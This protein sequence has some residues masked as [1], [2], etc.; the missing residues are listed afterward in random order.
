MTPQGLLD[1]FAAACADY[2][3]FLGL[4]IGARLCFRLNKELFA[5]AFTALDDDLVTRITASARNGGSGWSADECQPGPSSVSVEQ[6]LRATL[7]ELYQLQAS[8]DPELRSFPFGNPNRADSIDNDFIEL[9]RRN[10]KFIPVLNYIGLDGDNP[11]GQPMTRRSKY[12][13]TYMHPCKSHTIVHSQTCRSVF[14]NA[15]KTSAKA[16]KGLKMLLARLPL[17]SR[18]AS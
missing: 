9:G 16:R 7:E 1:F 4:Q 15:L 6:R 14:L 5:A 2:V 12:T 11:G 8:D 13:H 18:R 3:N 10:A 17:I